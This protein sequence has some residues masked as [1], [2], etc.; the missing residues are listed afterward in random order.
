MGRK[1]GA[2]K[3]KEEEEEEKEAKIN[4]L[5]MIMK[6]WIIYMWILRFSLSFRLSSSLVVCGGCAWPREKLLA[7]AFS[8][9]A[10]ACCPHKLLVHWWWW[11]LTAQL[12]SSCVV[13]RRRRCQ[14]AHRAV[15]NNLPIDFLFP[16][17]PTTTSGLP[18]LSCCPTAVW[19]AGSLARLLS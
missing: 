1:R 8:P 2:L 4:F 18:V 13:A 9:T 12:Q 16:T 5:L 10:A 14:N 3:V 6:L 19:L 11:L 15:T 17:H 7:P